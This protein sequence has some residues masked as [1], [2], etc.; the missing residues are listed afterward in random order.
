MR[1]NII[2]RA[3]LILSAAAVSAAL[4]LAPAGAAT[5][6]VAVP[7][8]VVASAVHPAD[9]GFGDYSGPGG[10]DHHDFQDDQDHGHPGIH[11]L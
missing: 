1:T 3:G 6:A 7:T 2:T 11:I 10:Y 5:N 8:A 9:D 4:A